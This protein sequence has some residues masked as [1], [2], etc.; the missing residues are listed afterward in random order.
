MPAVVNGGMK[1]C[2]SGEA[3]DACREHQGLRH[4]GCGMPRTKPVDSAPYEEG[5]EDGIDHLSR[6]QAA[7]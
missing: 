5:Y 1:A 2:A 7:G 6:T 3:L 4:S